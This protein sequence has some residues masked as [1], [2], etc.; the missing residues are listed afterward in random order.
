MLMQSLEF[1]KDR[2]VCYLCEIRKPHCSLVTFKVPEIHCIIFKQRMC[3]GIPDP[4]MMI[5]VR[6]LNAGQLL[7]MRCP[8]RMNKTAALKI[9]VDACRRV[10]RFIIIPQE[11]LISVMDR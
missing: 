4:I 9:S 2:A 10:Y 8:E 5:M 3:P 11:V 1:R 7:P 6:R